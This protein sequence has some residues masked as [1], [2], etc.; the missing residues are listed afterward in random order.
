MLSVTASTTLPANRTITLGANGGTINIPFTSGGSPDDGATTPTVRILGQITGP[1]GLTVTGGNGVNSPGS[2]SSYLLVLDSL[3]NNYSGNTIINNA[4]VTNDNTITGVNILPPTTVLMLSNSA[5]FAFYSNTSSQTLAGLSGDSTTAIGSENNSS[6][7]ALT[8]DPAAGQSYTYYGNIGDVAVNGRGHSGSGGIALSLTFSGLGTEV[9]AGLKTDAGSTTITSGTV[10]LANVNALAAGVVADNAVG[11]G[12]IFASSGQ[13]YT[14]GGLSGSGNFSLSGLSGGSM[15]LNVNGNNTT[16]YSGI[17][18]GGGNLTLNGSGGTGVLYLTNT[19]AYAGG[20]TVS[21][22]TL[23]INPNSALNSNTSLIGTGALTIN[24][25]ATVEAYESAFGANSTQPPIVI[26]GGVLNQAG[27]SNIHLGTVTMTAGTMSGL[28]GTDYTYLTP[29]TITTNS[30]STTALISVSTLELKATTTFNVAAGNSAAPD[31][32]V[33]SQIVQDAATYGITKTGNGWMELTGS[34]TFAG[35]TT[36]GAGTLELGNVGALQNSTVTDNVANGGLIFATSGQAYKVGGLSGGG[37]I[38]LSNVSGGS[39]TLNITGGTNTTLATT[40]SGV[41]SGNGGLTNS[42]DELVLNNVNTF[43][44]P[45]TISGGTLQLANFNAIKNSTLTDNATGGVSFASSGVYNVAGLAGSS[46]IALL[47]VSGGSVTL[48][49]SGSNNVASVYSG[50][51]T[52]SGGLTVAGSGVEVLAGSNTYAGPTTITSG[53][54]Q[55]G[56]GASNGSVSTATITDNSVLALD[57][58]TAQTF[59]GLISGS[60]GL[61]KLGPNTLVLGNVGTAFSGSTTVSGGMLSIAADADLGQSRQRPPRPL[62]LSTAGDCK[63]PRFRPPIPPRSIAI[64]ASRSA[65]PAGRSKSRPS[66]RAHSARTRR[67]CSTAARSAAQA[68]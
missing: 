50:A 33:S 43:S 42:G 10:E 5:V 61:L 2:N 9:L 54:L 25:G 16:T 29:S 65:L 12:L 55:L 51:L 18:S 66:H 35:G 14:V 32:V 41:L 13:T 58:G 40:Y 3:T 6:A 23:V 62:S 47:G 39:L 48:N 46:S 52:G 56:N 53:T 68:T 17:I 11:N 21:G 64:E 45:A 26:N 49:I 19:N 57:N 28:G 38:T 8:I 24:A 20:T 60:G 7:A 27:S 36:I 37:N 1:G 15:T 22:G 59:S 44:G 30:A 67:P 34:N 31:L 63:S 4:T